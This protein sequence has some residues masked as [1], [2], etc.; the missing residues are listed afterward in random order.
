MSL[1]SPIDRTARL[2]VVDDDARL[3]RLLAATLTKHGFWVAVAGSALEAENLRAAEQYDLMVLDVMMEGES[4]VEYTA[5]LRQ[6]GDMQPILL[7]TALGDTAHRI[8]GLEVGADDYLPKPFEPLELVYRIQA[9]LRRLPP[10]ALPV[11]EISLPP[12]CFLPASRQLW[13]DETLIPLT[14]VEAAVLGLLAARIGTAV[15]RRELAQLLGN[16]TD[17]RAVDVTITR[18]RKKLEQPLWLQTVRGEGYVL[19]TPPAAP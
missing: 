11:T 3:R 10:P 2:L 12:Y 7:L 15:S 6:N 14:E 1:K 13:K 17:S 9:I 19:V 16:D 8:K 4:G 5:R 18:L